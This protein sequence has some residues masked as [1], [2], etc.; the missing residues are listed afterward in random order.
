MSRRARSRV[1]AG[2]ARAGRG[3][4][5]TR[6]RAAGPRRETLDHRLA[7]EAPNQQRQNQREERQR[8]QRPGLLDDRDQREQQCRRSKDRNAPDSVPTDHAEERTDPEGSPRRLSRVARG[9]S[10]CTIDTR[11]TITGTA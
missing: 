8:R 3:C 9:A 4:G 7:R 2:G 5:G 11:T 6:Q 10:S 1:G